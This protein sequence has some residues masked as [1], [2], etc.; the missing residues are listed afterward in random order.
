LKYGFAGFYR[1]YEATCAK[2]CFLRKVLFGN[3]RQRRETLVEKVDNAKKRQRRETLVKG[4]Q[5]KVF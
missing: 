2:R 4:L 1:G 5:T 3:K